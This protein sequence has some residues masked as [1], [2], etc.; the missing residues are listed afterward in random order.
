MSVNLPQNPIRGNPPENT[1]PTPSMPASHEIELS[2]L[3][4]K[5][6]MV[7]GQ[8]VH[9]KKGIL[10]S[11]A[12]FFESIKTYFAMKSLESDFLTLKGKIK[13]FDPAKDDITQLDE[14]VKAVKTAFEKI[15]SNISDPIKAIK[16]KALEV[17]LCHLTHQ[18]DILT[19]RE[20]AP[21]P[22]PPMP[23]ESVPIL[24][25]ESPIE[26][27]AT[28]THIQASD[29][30]S[31]DQLIHN[32]RRFP[33]VVPFPTSDNRIESIL[34]RDPTKADEIVAFANDT[35][36]IMHHK[37]QALI[38]D[39]LNFKQ[40]HG[41]EIE[42]DVYDTMD[43]NA[44]IDRLLTNR[45]LV[46]MR[47]D[48]TFIIKEGFIGNG[49]FEQIGTP[50]EQEPVVLKNYLSYEEMQISALLGVSVPTHFIN[51]GDRLNKGVLGKPG[52][53]EE[54]GVYVGLVGARFEKPGLMEWQ[55]MIITPEQNTTANGYGI[56]PNT[57]A[58]INQKLAMWSKLYGETFPTFEEAQNDHTGKYIP[59]ADNTFLNASV[60]KERMRLVLEPFL[61][62]ANQRARAAG[63]QAYI[64][65]VGLGL[66]EWQKTPQQAHL[67]LE[68][69]ADII[70][71]QDLQHISD[72]DFSWFQG[73][74]Q[75]GGV[76]NQGVLHTEHN[77][78]KIHFSKRNPADKLKGADSDKLLVASY[79]WD[80]NAY[81]GNEYWIGM[82]AASGDP[83]AACCSTIPELQN[84][85]INPHVAAIN[86][87][88]Y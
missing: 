48:D 44:F 8:T 85:V 27:P 57:D 21:P 88:A 67:M 41:N 72:I 26:R 42:R 75:C 60:Y 55:H 78:I 37:V 50:L 6:K 63:K 68:V 22:E 29:Y 59:I 56:A 23:V 35:H 19:G 34:A 77:A 83:A 58:P 71:K 52:S 18:L 62:D 16:F 28:P 3:E 1:T 64:H 7:G 12:A 51:D 45:P 36:P 9:P 70:S 20:L 32:A 14:S 81:P 25:P 84:P 73:C 53:Y 76:E 38:T 86:L 40:T 4:N 13:N 47:K 33:T 17:G 66:G 79:A 65:A 80:S 15:E 11:I 82:L 87:Q 43:V 46:F 2:P 24:Q 31:L 5:T 54:K 61:L 74:T 30:D 69:Y 49:G 39:F 10:T